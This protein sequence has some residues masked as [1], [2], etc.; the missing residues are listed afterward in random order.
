[1]PKIF[2]NPLPD[3]QQKAFDEGKNGVYFSDVF[4]SKTD[5]NKFRMLVTAPAFDSNSLLI[6]RH[7][8]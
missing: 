5:G 4:S 2:L 8:F 6:G 3:P 1:M 7:R